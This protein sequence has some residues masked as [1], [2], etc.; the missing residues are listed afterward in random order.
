MATDAQTLLQIKN[1]KTNFYLDHSPNCAL[2]EED[3][4][5]RLWLVVRSLKSPA[6]KYDY[7]IRKFDVIKLGRVKFRIKDFACQFMGQ[8]P[9][10]LL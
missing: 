4:T 9:D 8:T 5:D 3:G 10:E 1:N 2:D 7:Q 6:G